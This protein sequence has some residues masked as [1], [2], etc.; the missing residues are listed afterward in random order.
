[1][2]IS[3]KLWIK[4]S[5]LFN[6]GVL[7]MNLQASKIY[8]YFYSSLAAFMLIL[9]DWIFFSSFM[10]LIKFTKS[11]KVL[12]ILIKKHPLFVS[13]NQLQYI[14]LLHKVKIQF[15]IHV[16]KKIIVIFKN[17]ATMFVLKQFIFSKESLEK[18]FY[19]YYFD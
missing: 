6:S 3:K 2:D 15:S 19:I 5:F 1:M 12:R 4:L 13:V 18:I 8:C 14:K 9:S 17:L 7:K 11:L 10:Y 16:Q